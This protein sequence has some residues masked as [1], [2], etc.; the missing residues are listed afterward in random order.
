MRPIQDFV[1]QP[2]TL[3]CISKAKRPRKFR[4][5]R[6]H[7]PPKKKLKNRRKMAHFYS[8]L[9]T[10]LL[11]SQRWKSLKAYIYIVWRDRVKLKLKEPTV[12]LRFGNSLLKS[13]QLKR[14]LRDLPI[15]FKLNKK[16][17]KGDESVT[18]TIRNQVLIIE[19]FPFNAMDR[20][21]A[22][23]ISV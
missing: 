15:I 12:L 2:L 1:I 18:T 5:V 14:K 10:F 22:I 4:G 7:A 13:A 6:G 9:V 21:W 3:Y 19:L 16:M 23:F 11:F 8:H 20:L 17:L